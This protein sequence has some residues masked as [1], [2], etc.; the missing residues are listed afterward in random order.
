MKRIRHISIALIC[1]L[2][3]STSLPAAES[4]S[5]PVENKVKFTG[6]CYAINK[7]DEPPVLKER[8]L[9]G[10]PAGG[11]AMMAFVVDEKGK[12]TQVQIAKASSKEFGEA[13][14]K[15]VEKW[16]Y[17]PGKKDGKPVS[18]KIMLPLKTD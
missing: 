11:Q 16:T 8:S 1:A 17:R 15:A 2:F 9:A 13:A 10:I 18:V 4:A 6:E 5:G 3:V 12:T 7:V 14:K